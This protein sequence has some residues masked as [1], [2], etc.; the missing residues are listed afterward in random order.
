M[1]QVI[2][3]PLTI[4]KD[5]RR[6]H[7]DGRHR[8]HGK[9]CPFRTCHIGIDTKVPEVLVGNLLKTGPYISRSQLVLDLFAFLNL[10]L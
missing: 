8:K 5:D 9:N 6:A 1:G 2:F 10:D 7:R 4:L 3:R